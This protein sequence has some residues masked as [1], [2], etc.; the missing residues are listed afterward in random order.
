MIE[1]TIAT[2][3][4]GVNYFTTHRLL[5]PDKKWHGID[6][7]LIDPRLLDIYPTL[8]NELKTLGLRQVYYDIEWDYLYFAQT[9]PSYFASAIQFLYQIYWGIIRWLY[10][11]GKVFQRIPDGERFSWRYFTPIVFVKVGIKW[12]KRQR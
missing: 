4:N 8:E 7:H 12:F 10:H 6:V 9:L 2:M 1:T 5:K 3:D 11:Y